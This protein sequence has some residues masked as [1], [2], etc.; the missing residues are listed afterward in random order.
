MVVVHVEQH[1]SRI[2]GR[3][4][5]RDAEGGGKLA[6]CMQIG[7]FSFARLR[8]AYEPRCLEIRLNRARTTAASLRED[9][10]AVDDQRERER[11]REW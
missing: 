2:R 11:E 10:S 5:I 4:C 6:R 7:N 1:Y 9:R 8:R 3:I